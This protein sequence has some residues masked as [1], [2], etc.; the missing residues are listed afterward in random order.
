MGLPLAEGLTQ[1][2]PGVRAA[3]PGEK[4]GGGGGQGLARPSESV[5]GWQHSIGGD[6]RV[7]DGAVLRAGSLAAPAADCIASACI[8]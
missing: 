4:R 6:L 1:T 7:M 2:P 5:A 3:G 8:L